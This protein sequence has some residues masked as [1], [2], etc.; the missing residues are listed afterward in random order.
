MTK[1]LHRRIAAL[2]ILV[3]VVVQ[4]G[5]ILAADLYH[6][7]P[8]VAVVAQLGDIEANDPSEQSATMGAQRPMPSVDALI[9]AD[10]AEHCGGA[11]ILMSRGDTPTIPSRWGRIRPPTISFAAVLPRRLERPPKSAVSLA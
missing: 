7:D 8:W 10:C 11:A 1:S 2:L 3:V 5:V 9:V 4:A 6:P